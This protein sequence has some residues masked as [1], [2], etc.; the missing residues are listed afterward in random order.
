VAP[1]TRRSAI[2]SQPMTSLSPTNRKGGTS[3]P[4]ASCRRHMSAF[5]RAA[6]RQSDRGP[7][8]GSDP[9]ADE[10]N[11]GV[12]ITGVFPGTACS[13]YRF[14]EWP[15]GAGPSRLALPRCPAR[16]A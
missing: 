10:M 3:R 2:P 9:D 15:A 16:L 5:R 4:Y 13:A 7:R 6:R 12:Q 11:L 14:Q 1:P 8:P